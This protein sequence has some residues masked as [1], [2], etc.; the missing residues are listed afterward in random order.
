MTIHLRILVH[1]LDR[2]GPPMLA[3][4][5]LRWAAVHRSDLSLDLVAFRGGPLST[6][7][8]TSVPVTVVLDDEEPWDHSR[9]DPARAAELRQ[10]LSALADARTTLLVSV[11]AGQCLPLLAGTGSRVVTWV[12]ER[13]DDLHWLGP[14]VDVAARTDRW[15][16]GSHST[17]EELATLPGVQGS[18]TVACEFIETP[19]V[20]PSVVAALRHQLAP[21]GSTLVI[22]AGIGT[23]RK[24]PDLFVEAALAHRRLGAGPTRFVWVGGE[25]DPLVPRLRRWVHERALTDLVGFVP[26]TSA[27]DEHL[28]AADVFLHTA[29]LDAFPLVCLHAAA[30]GVPVVAFDGGGGPMEMFGDTFVGAPY[31]DVA[32]LASRVAELADSAHRREVAEQQQRRVLEHFTSDGAA[33]RVLD[34]ALVPSATAR[35][36]R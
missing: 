27:L 22:G 24:A 14:P 32:V 10:R 21:A 26:S 34:L 18:V 17:A 5:L 4:A 23:W 25:R 19:V 16:A 2:T 28:A 11:A 31:P 13:E 30:S 20:D 33:G 36:T 12:V 6:E 1:A 29:R 7:L 3:R 15:L 8:P 35:A 9:P